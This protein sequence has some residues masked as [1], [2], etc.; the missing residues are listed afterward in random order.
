M[1]NRWGRISS[2]SV[3]SCCTIGT[4]CPDHELP[5]D[6]TTSGAEK[7]PWT[8]TVPPTPGLTMML[9]ELINESAVQNVASRNPASLLQTITLP[10][11]QVLI[12][13]ASTPHI[14]EPQHRIGWRHFDEFG[15]W[16][17]GDQGL[18]RR[19]K[20]GLDLGNM[21]NRINLIKLWG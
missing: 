3:H 8:V 14:N 2:W 12:T 5:N 9:M 19:A 6:R 15:G 1:S 18:K 17:G 21:E 11:Y 20:D 16:R 7:A 4:D 13:S 10:V